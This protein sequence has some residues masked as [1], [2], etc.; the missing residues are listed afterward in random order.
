MCGFRILV[1]WASILNHGWSTL[2][3]AFG[4]RFATRHRTE[5][6]VWENLHDLGGQFSSVVS[7]EALGLASLAGIHILAYSF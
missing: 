5:A 1:R 2:D 7:R 3:N 4:D 6:D